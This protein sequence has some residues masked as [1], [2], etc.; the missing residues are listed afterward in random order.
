M[1]LNNFF[2]HHHFCNSIFIFKMEDFSHFTKK[3][4]YMKTKQNWRFTEGL[5]VLRRS[6]VILILCFLRLDRASTVLNFGTQKFAHVSRFLKCYFSVW[7]IRDFSWCENWCHGAKIAHPGAAPRC[8]TQVPLHPG[9][10]PR[11]CT[12]VLHPGTAPPKVLHPQVLHPGTAPR[13]CTLVL[14]PGAA[15]RYC[16]QVLHPGTAPRCCKGLLCNE[17]I[18]TTFSI[19]FGT[20]F[21]KWV[22]RKIHFFWT[23]GA[24]KYGQGTVLARFDAK[25]KPRTP[26][27]F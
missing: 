14:H 17:K 8:C 18:R 10:A 24:K 21:C 12:E 11:C 13:C 25:T 23:T 2:Y 27:K 1:I 9:T 20:K 3:R 6:S 5:C 15:P 22:K 19:M 26:I 16:T 7:P 4:F